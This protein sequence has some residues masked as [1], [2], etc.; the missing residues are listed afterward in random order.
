MKM[1]TFI[2]RAVLLVLDVL[3]E[4]YASSKGGGGKKGK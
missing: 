2:R 4:L 1:K 3:V